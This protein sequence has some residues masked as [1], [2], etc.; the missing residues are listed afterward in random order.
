MDRRMRRLFAVFTVAS[1]FGASACGGGQ[2][3]GRDGAGG[4]GTTGAVTE[5][6]GMP[7]PAEKQAASP[8][9]GLEPYWPTA[10]FRTA[11]PADLGMDANTLEAAATFAPSGSSNQAIVVVRHGYIAFE[12][13]FG[14][15]TATTKHESYSMA[16]SFSSALVGIAIDKGL[17]ASTEE[18]L[19]QYYSEWDCADSSDPRS[20]ITVAHAMNIATGLDWHEDWRTGAQGTNDVYLAGNNMLD[21]VLSKPA[22]T[23]PGTTIRYS[24]GDPSL[25]SGVLQSVTGKTA[26]AFAEEVLL[27]PLGITDLTWGSDSKGRTTTYAGI[28][29]TARDFA[30]YGYLY[31]KNGTWDGQQIVPPAWIANTTRAVDPC[32][33]VYRFLWHINPPIRL[34]TPDP[35]CP[36]LLGCQPLDI[37]DLP[38]DAFFAEGIYGQFIFVVPSA[39]LVVVRLAQDG[40]GSEKWDAYARGFL[41]LVLSSVT[42]S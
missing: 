16:K 35:A 30:K 11:D 31:L 5:C 24:T 12:R 42:D 22:A 7:F 2:S 9:A 34:G 23:E 4:G 21:Y 33:D 17:L 1:A 37:A 20:R 19:C 38:P 14:S 40:P 26:F 39:D 41:S 10:A 32:K 3:D 25:L 29:A 8:K 28:Q 27:A 6:F 36:G 18:R 13:Y 15:F